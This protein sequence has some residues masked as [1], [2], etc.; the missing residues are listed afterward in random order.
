MSAWYSFSLILSEKAEKTLNMHDNFAYL[1]LFFTLV[2]CIFL[3]IESNLVR[4][5]KMR[6]TYIIPLILIALSSL[7][8]GITGH[9]GASLTHVHNIEYE[10]NDHC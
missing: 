5:L 9:Y 8:V 3:I 2:S 6:I 10:K 4:F 7:T 1:T